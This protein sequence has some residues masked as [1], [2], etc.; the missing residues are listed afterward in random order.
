MSLWFDLLLVGIVIWG[1]IAGFLKGPR[2][3]L[4]RFGLFTVLSLLAFAGAEPCALYIGPSIEPLVASGYSHLALPAAAMPASF[5]P[6]QPL[7]L[8]RAATGASFTPLSLT[9]NIATMSLLLVAMLVVAR[10]FAKPGAKAFSPGGL[11]VGI[12]SGL[13]GA[14]LFSALA[15]VLIL[16]RLGAALALGAGESH[17]A[18]WL[19]P[20]ARLLVRLIA[21]FVL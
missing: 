15:P 13:A 5:G 2:R 20:V 14:V 17:L 6:W 19:T 18:G 1:G 21:P 16:G 9:V 3:A 4:L 10:L 8:A 7:L 12:V 11:A